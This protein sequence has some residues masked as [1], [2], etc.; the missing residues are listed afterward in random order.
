M[1][2][3]N[4]AELRRVSLSAEIHGQ[5]DVAHHHQ[6]H[7][8]TPEGVE[9]IHSAG[10]GIPG[11]AYCGIGQGIF[12][13]SVSAR[14]PY[15]RWSLNHSVMIRAVFESAAKVYNYSVSMRSADNFLQR[16][17]VRRRGAPRPI[18]GPQ[19]RTLARNPTQESYRKHRNCRGPQGLVGMQRIEAPRNA[20][21]RETH[22]NARPQ[23]L[24]VCADRRKLR[25]PQDRR[26]SSD[27]R[28]QGPTWTAKTAETEQPEPQKPPESRVQR[29]PVPPAETQ[30]PPAPH[31]CGSRREF[32]TNA[33]AGTFRQ[34]HPFYCGCAAAPG[35]RPAGQRSSLLFAA[36]SSPRLPDRADHQVVVIAQ[37]PYR[38]GSGDPDHVLLQVAPA[39]RPCLD[40]GLVESPSWS[41]GTYGRM[42]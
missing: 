20:G 27:R 33:P 35:F 37:T 40:G 4:R 36:R 6:H 41:P 21:I 14:A 28:N 32:G 9:F 13:V 31:I 10:E 42:A 2:N 38:R 3:V 11:G 30:N 34:K 7:G 15:A 19:R 8:K 12:I 1:R 5:Q 29:P 26:N 16:A 22:R 24:Q 23:E 25:R 17:V 39:D 18:P